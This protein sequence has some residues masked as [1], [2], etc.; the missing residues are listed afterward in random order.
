VDFIL[1][2]AI[3]DYLYHHGVQVLP[4]SKHC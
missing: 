2:I 3:F 4:K 1:Y